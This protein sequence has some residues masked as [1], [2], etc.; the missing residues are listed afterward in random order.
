MK[1]Y[2]LTDHTP[3]WE[4][5]PRNPTELKFRGVMIAPGGHI[6]ADDQYLS[7]LAGWV[8]GH[9]ASVN[10]LPAW[11]QAA[12]QEK[13]EADK[14]KPLEPVVEAVKVRRRKSEES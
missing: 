1:V 13:R 3:A 10:S 7:E 2:N 8:M 6:T 14:P 9:T 4:K 12:Q 5:I 11:Y